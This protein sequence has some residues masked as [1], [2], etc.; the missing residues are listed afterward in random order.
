MT[1]SIVRWE[2]TA[3]TKGGAPGP[4]PT[5]GSREHGVP[6]V[7]AA[8]AGFASSGSGLDNRTAR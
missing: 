7:A 8:T 1:R 2:T 5:H 4:Y 6:L 3:F